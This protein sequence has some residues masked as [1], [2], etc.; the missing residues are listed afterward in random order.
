MR[1][2]IVSRC[3]RHLS[4]RYCALST[5]SFVFFAF[6]F[7]QKYWLAVWKV[8]FKMDNPCKKKN[9]GNMTVCLRQ[10]KQKGNHWKSMPVWLLDRISKRDSLL[11]LSRWLRDF[12]HA[13]HFPPKRS[14]LFAHDLRGQKQ[15]PKV[16][17]WRMTR[18]R[19]VILCG[20]H[21]IFW[22]L[23]QHIFVSSRVVRFRSYLK[24]V[25]FIYL[26]KRKAENQS[27]FPTGTNH[28]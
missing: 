9:D 1:R 11:E 4:T 16:L 12:M 6:L 10:G 28:I 27:S 17:G 25:G 7:L 14:Y 5:F 21:L 22:A 26:W 24:V 18:E 15:R 19:A 13:S 8:K 20:R 2:G 23:K 3:C